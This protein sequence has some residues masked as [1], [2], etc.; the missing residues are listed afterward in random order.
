MNERQIAKKLD[1]ILSQE[2]PDLQSQPDEI[3]QL[4]EIAELIKNAPVV[5]LNKDH[6]QIMKFKLLKKLPP[7]TSVVTKS[8]DFRFNLRKY[9]DYPRRRFAMNLLLILA[10]LLSLFGGVGAVYASDNSVP[11]DMLYPVKTLVE[12]AR[13]ILANNESDIN[14]LLDFLDERVEEIRT[15]LDQNEPDKL[16]TAVDGYAYR[17]QQLEMS[18]QQFRAENLLEG[19]TLN[20]RVNVRLQEQVNM[21]EGFAL[22]AGEMAEVRERIQNLEMINNQNRSVDSQHEGDKNLNEGQNLN[23]NAGQNQSKEQ[24]KEDHAAQWNASLDTYSITAENQLMFTYRI[25][26]NNMVKN[27]YV[28]INDIRYGCEP[29]NP[30]MGTVMCN[31]PQPTSEQVIVELFDANTDQVL[32]SSMLLMQHMEMKMNSGNGQKDNMDSTD[33]MDSN[34]GDKNT[35]K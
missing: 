18:M 26:S 5:E 20:A 7:R 27:M 11:G 23:N 8:K 34:H 15:L 35:K 13:L 30:E 32:C 21:M 1:N 2:E 14:L 29:Y 33:K 12:D 25:Q 9:F 19:D 22:K 10:T 16:L 4:Y 28:R 3:R 31:T 6:L 24:E 17:F